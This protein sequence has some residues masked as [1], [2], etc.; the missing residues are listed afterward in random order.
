MRRILAGLH[1]FVGGGLFQL[2]DHPRN[3]P[4]SRTSKTRDPVLEQ[5]ARDMV[6]ELAPSLAPLL[7]VGWNSRMRT[8]AGV[9]IASCRE[10]WLNPALREIS[11]EE[12]DRTL[13]HELAH[14]LAQHRHGRRRLAP[15][16]PEWRQACRDLGIPGEGRTHQLPFTARRI[17]RRYLLRCPGC[18]ESHDRVRIPRRRIACLSCCRTHNRGIYDERFR[19]VVARIAEE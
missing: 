11:L 16:G 10:I 15:H 12:V 17:K 7:V 1:R 5:R 14:L 18:G 8:T 3:R 4:G 6:R 19:F 9:A 2:P 13:L